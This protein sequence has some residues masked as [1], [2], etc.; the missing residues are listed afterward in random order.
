M[1]R[2]FR[3]LKKFVVNM[4][5]TSTNKAFQV[6]KDPSGLESS[7]NG[8]YEFLTHFYI[9]NRPKPCVHTRIEPINLVLLN[10]VIQYFH[11]IC[12]RT[13][14]ELVNLIKPRDLPFVVT[15]RD[16][17]R[18]RQINDCIVMLILKAFCIPSS[19]DIRPSGTEDERRL[20]PGAPNAPAGGGRG[21]GCGGG[22]PEGVLGE[23]DLL[24]CL[25]RALA[26]YAE[27]DS[28][29]HDLLTSPVLHRGSCD[30]HG[31]HG[32]ELGEPNHCLS[33]KLSQ[34]LCSTSEDIK[35]L[36]VVEQ[37]KRQGSSGA[38]LLSR[39]L[40]TAKVPSFKGDQP[41]PHGL[42]E[43]ET[44]QSLPGFFESAYPFICLPGLI[45]QFLSS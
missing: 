36:Q 14:T 34:R 15:D 32:V 20:V 37:G 10:S 7:F 39:T 24:R 5:N 6:L 23:F 19:C 35:I 31:E 4:A 2:S 43:V 21:S 17:N 18:S 11:N 3:S 13:I 8:M 33:Q 30:L 9:L 44:L 45:Q 26:R 12:Q 29:G 25:L 42:V 28:N 38:G 40:E 1:K 16:H 27:V 22:G 41:E